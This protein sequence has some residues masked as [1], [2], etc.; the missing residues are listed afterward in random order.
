MMKANQATRSRRLHA[1]GNPH[2][3]LAYACPVTAAPL[4]LAFVD[5]VIDRAPTIRKNFDPQATLSADGRSITLSRA[6]GLC[7]AREKT[8]E[9]QAQ[10][11]QQVTRASVN[12]RA[13]RRC[14]LVHPVR[15]VITAKVDAGKPAF[16]AGPA[17]VCGTG[18]SRGQA[19]H[20]CRGLV[21][22]RQ[23]GEPMSVKR[24]V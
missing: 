15:F 18:I 22:L 14:L 7:E 1:Q 2:Q 3:I 4:T 6:I 11:T 10:I 24:A 17:Q 13:I 9:V 16:V 12:G 8:A 5:P 19:D 23:S 21:H 20:R